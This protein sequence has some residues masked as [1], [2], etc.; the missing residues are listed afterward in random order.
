MTDY[1]PRKQEKSSQIQASFDIALLTSSSNSGGEV[2]QIAAYPPV[3][4]FVTS[5]VADG[6]RLPA[7][8]KR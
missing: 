5:F 3:G 4:Q 7:E 2:H 6:R 1:I 8:S